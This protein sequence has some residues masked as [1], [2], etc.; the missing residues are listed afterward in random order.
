MSDA[1]ALIGAIIASIG[2]LVGWLFASLFYRRRLGVH[3]N[4]VTNL[5]KKLDLAKEQYDVASAEAAQLKASMTLL[6]NEVWKREARQENWS[7]VSVLI[8]AAERQL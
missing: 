1:G 4:S 6:K 2:A 8:R 5:K 7:D 3:E